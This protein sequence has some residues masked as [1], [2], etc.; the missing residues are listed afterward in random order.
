MLDI[1]P[2]SLLAFHLTIIIIL[3][4]TYFLY[5]SIYRQG[6]KFR[7][8]KEI[9]LRS[10]NQDLGL[11]FEYRSLILKTPLLS[12]VSLPFPGK[13]C[14][15]FLWLGAGE[16]L[17]SNPS[18]SLFTSPLH[19]WEPNVNQDGPL[20]VLARCGMIYM[21]PHQLGWKPLKDSYM[22]T[23]PSSLTEEHKELVRPSGPFPFC[24]SLSPDSS[25]PKAF[26]DR[27]H[28]HNYGRQGGVGNSLIVP[29]YIASWLLAIIILFYFACGAGI[30]Q[31]ISAFS[32]IS[33]ITF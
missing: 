17:C 29:N 6:L 20:F 2:N 28:I 9:F 23:L 27:F 25:S 33:S 31:S 15:S 18:S 19:A 3:Q 11:R 8:R 21:E 22:D 30:V 5:S 14:A 32:S 16:G 12:L 7:D 4:A 1:V 13:I 24:P 10:L 26:Q